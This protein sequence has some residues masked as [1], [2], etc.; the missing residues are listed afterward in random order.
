MAP[1]SRL[2]LHTVVDT[3]QIFSTD[4]QKILIILTIVYLYSIWIPVLLYKLRELL[5]PRTRHSDGFLKRHPVYLFLLYGII[6]FHIAIQQPL[7]LL[8]LYPSKT[9][10][11]DSN[12]N[13]ESMT[14]DIVEIINFAVVTA[15]FLLFLSRSWILFHDYRFNDS[16]ANLCW[17]SSLQPTVWTL[18]LNPFQIP[19][20][21]MFI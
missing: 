2:L 18:Y 16:I 17:R 21:R 10:F 12:L 3:T 8:I 5:R 14:G 4:G 15:F 6:L 9:Y 7:C 20:C 1:C 11:P 13:Y 19:K